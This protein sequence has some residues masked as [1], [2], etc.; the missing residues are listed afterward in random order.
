MQFVAHAFWNHNPARVVES[1]GSI[2]TGSIVRVDPGVKYH[3]GVPPSPATLYNVPVDL[4]VCVATELEGAL[5]RPHLPVLCT[6]V[7]AVNAAY[8]LTRFLDRTGA[9]AIVVCGIG[10]AYPGSNLAIGTVV[11]A[12]TECYGDLGAGSPTGFLDMQALGFPLISRPSP[13]YNI[14]PLQLHPNARRVPFVTVNTCSGDDAT[15]LAL[16][17]R[18][19]GCVENMEGAAIAHVATLFGIPVGEIRGISNSVG[20]RDRAAWRVKEAATAAQ[21]SLLLAWR[22]GGPTFSNTIH[23]SAA[24]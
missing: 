8:T 3:F 18:T 24:C 12:E 7:G 11:C 6:G 1:H 5:L 21:E 9:K 14:F 19:G 10:G 23:E 13:L 4:V 22:R 16:A 20:N 17:A 15:A 2:H